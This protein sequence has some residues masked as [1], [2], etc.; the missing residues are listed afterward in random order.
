MYRIN[1]NPGKAATIKGYASFPADFPHLSPGQDFAAWRTEE[2]FEIET[3]L[4]GKALEARLKAF[5]E[6]GR[7]KYG[8]TFS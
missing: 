7:E 3:T 1:T 5:Q 2:G 6:Q 8:Q 4:G